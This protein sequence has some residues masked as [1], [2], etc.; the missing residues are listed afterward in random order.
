[1]SEAF[2]EPIQVAHNGNVWGRVRSVYSHQKV[3]D[4]ISS[5][6]MLKTR[7]VTWSPPLPL[8]CSCYDDF[9]QGI[10]ES[11]RGV[12]RL[13]KDLPAH[14]RTKICNDAETLHAKAVEEL[15]WCARKLSPESEARITQTTS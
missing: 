13:T 9:D 10:S 1:M 14:Y 12:S 2:A 4:T 11:L 5:R 15:R 8:V 6:R 7:L 3:S